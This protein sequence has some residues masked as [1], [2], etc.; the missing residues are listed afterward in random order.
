[1]AFG[2]DDLLLTPDKS[3]QLTKALSGLNVADPLQYFCDEAA[4]EVARMTT[5]YLLDDLSVRGLTRA[6]AL[7]KIYSFVAPVPADIQKD[8]DGASK[9]LEAIAKGERP[10]LPKQQTPTSSP[11]AGTSSSGSQLTGRIPGQI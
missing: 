3:A 7:F 8:Y 11:T 6:I 10:N 1:M 4:A 9:E 5:G 2:E